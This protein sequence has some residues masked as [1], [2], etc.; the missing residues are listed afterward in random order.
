MAKRSVPSL[1]HASPSPSPPSELT[2][3][4]TAGLTPA[5]TTI[6]NATTATKADDRAAYKAFQKR[7]RYDRVAFVHDCFAWEEGQSP[8][9]YQDEILGLFDTCDRVAVYGPRSLGKCVPADEKIRLSDG[10]LV[11]A[12]ELIGH[13][14]DVL[15]VD[16][17]LSVVKA[18]A[19]AWDNGIREVVRI[20]TDKGRVITRTLNH[21]LWADKT[22][23][24]YGP[25]QYCFRNAPE[26]S[27]V[28]AGD[29]SVGAAVAVYLGNETV[30][31][32]DIEDEAIKLCAYLLG[33][34]NVTGTELRV[35]QLE[36][37]ALSEIRECCDS[38]GLELRFQSGVDYRIVRKDRR[39]RGRYG[40]NRLRDA[41][42]SWGMR[43]VFARD[44][45]FP[46]WIWLLDDR[47]LALFLSRL[48]ACDGWASGNHRP[49]HKAKCNREVG[50]CS[51]S[52]QLVRDVSAA[53]LR[54]GIQS[55]I[56]RK[57]TSWTHKGEKKT[58]IAWGAYIHDLA[59]IRLFCERVGIFGKEAA[60][61]SLM[62]LCSKSALSRM[63]WRNHGLPKHMAWERVKEICVLSACETVAISVPGPETFLTEFVEHNTA[64]EAWIALHTAL[65]FDG[66][67]TRDWKMMV[68]A[69]AWGQLE[70]YLWPEISKWAAR[71]KWHKVG[72]PP[73]NT[74]TELL[75]TRLNLSKGHIYS[76]SPQKSLLMEGGHADFF[77]N[78][79][80][81]AK[82]VEDSV[83]DGAEGATFGAGEG[84]HQKAKFGAF[85]TPGDTSGRFYDICRHAP[86]LEDWRVR[87]VTLDECIAAGRISRE[88]VEA[89]ARQW[90]ESQLYK[91]HV[92]GV[93]WAS[94]EDG[95]IPLRWV[96]AATTRYN[97]SLAAHPFCIRVDD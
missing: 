95:I 9:P 58:G 68:T 8:A 36:G 60:I 77:F 47:Q 83:F 16:G 76:V 87:H 82:A 51:V 15:A 90:G 72:R 54:L 67:A 28:P 22:P 26:G 96:E 65:C 45:E 1:L 21:P 59:N 6:F 86:G 24:R 32:F 75:T 13:S 84:A 43:G 78:L 2:A 7:Y 64:A 55:E 97:E 18:G 14:F 89:R 48:F 52:E 25:P 57:K 61:A 79:F 44:K 27:W 38:W 31:P 29:L 33:D 49:G 10:S 71:L 70:D 46:S 92:E 11:P 85:S 53:L 3:S 94:E 30:D 91:N 63:Q 4:L 73:F 66:D 42:V 23:K 37:A 62:N 35:S 50:L 12:G 17:D 34:G 81:E 74:R 5:Q 80:D 56:R 39:S 19:L 93:F 41:V 69:G 88:K 20:V 40:K